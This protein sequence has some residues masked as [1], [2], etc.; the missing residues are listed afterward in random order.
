MHQ[1]PW[2]P[3]WLDLSDE[4]RLQLLSVLNRMLT[5]RLADGEVGNEEGDHEQH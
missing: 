2:A 5:D 1:R 3:I 4:L